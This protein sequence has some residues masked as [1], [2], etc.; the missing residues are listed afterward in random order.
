CVKSAIGI[1]SRSVGSVKPRAYENN[2]PYEPPRIG[3][4]AGSGGGR[5][6]PARV[7]NRECKKVRPLLC[8]LQEGERLPKAH[9]A[10]RAAGRIWT[11]RRL[12]RPARTGRYHHRAA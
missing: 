10:P 1:T 9:V 12:P 2:E 4:R 7:I 8:G 6:P 3:V 5:R 11:S